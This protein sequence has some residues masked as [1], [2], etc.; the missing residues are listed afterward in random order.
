MNQCKC[1]SYAINPHC[2][3]RESGV[4]LNLCDVCYWRTRAEAAKAA[5]VCPVKWKSAE[6]I[7]TS[8]ADLG[9]QWGVE[10]WFENKEQRER[11]CKWIK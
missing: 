8:G 6:R 3:G 7:F 4:D 10:F 1:G 9:N 11:F 2:H 5:S